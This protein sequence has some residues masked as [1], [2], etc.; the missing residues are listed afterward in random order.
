M[1]FILTKSYLLNTHNSLTM[2]QLHQENIFSL[3]EENINFYS[4]IVNDSYNFIV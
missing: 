1:D 2:F 4:K 3:N